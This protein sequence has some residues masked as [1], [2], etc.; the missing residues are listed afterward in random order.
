[1]CNGYGFTEW[2]LAWIS[3]TGPYS[4]DV[5]RQC[6]LQQDL[7]EHKAFRCHS[8]APSQSISCCSHSYG[9]GWQVPAEGKQRNSP[10]S[11]AMEREAEVGSHRMRWSVRP[12]GPSMQAARKKGKGRVV[13]L[14]ALGVCS[15]VEYFP[16]G[17]MQLMLS[18]PRKDGLGKQL[19]TMQKKKGNTSVS[20]NLVNTMKLKHCKEGKKAGEK[21]SVRNTSPITDVTFIYIYIFSPTRCP[22]SSDW[23]ANPLGIITSAP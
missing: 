4:E 1:M 12:H 17:L 8:S 10:G 20:A 3:T 14:C 5:S 21:D 18:N 22:Q 7:S 15:L 13:L 11:T 2:S 9:L 16:T 19:S 23:G 6:A